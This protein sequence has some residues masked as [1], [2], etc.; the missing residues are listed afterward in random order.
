MILL[1]EA[2]TTINLPAQVNQTA[3]HL[4]N[5]LLGG[6]LSYISGWLSGVRE[7]D[8]SSKWTELDSLR[9]D[10]SASLTFIA[11]LQFVVDA[12]GGCS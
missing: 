12:G 3:D 2:A 9:A 5:R 1:L 10:Q 6:L 4:I 8:F 7:G 11:G